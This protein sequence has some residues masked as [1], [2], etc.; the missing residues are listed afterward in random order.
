[1][2]TLT[3]LCV[4]WLGGCPG[5]GSG[6]VGGTLEEVPESATYTEHVGPIID[7]NCIRCHTDPPQN[8]APFSLEGY[9]NVVASA[10]RVIAR[11]V[12]EETMPPGGPVLGEIDQEVLQLWLDQ[13]TPE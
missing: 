6:T 9:D 13:G 1:M 3:L 8:G 11:A 10:D 2:R 12:D 4:L 7:T 5:A